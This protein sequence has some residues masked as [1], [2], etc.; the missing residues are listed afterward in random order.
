MRTR[1]F[2]MAASGG[3]IKKIFKIGIVVI[4]FAPGVRGMNKTHKIP[5]VLNRIS[6]L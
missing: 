6:I 5:F 2:N 1:T 3:D 4:T